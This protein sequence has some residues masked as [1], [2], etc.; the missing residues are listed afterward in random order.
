MEILKKVSQFIDANQ[1]LQENERI[2]V[3]VSGGSDSVVMLHILLK[4]GFECVVAHCNFHLRGEESMRDELFVEKLAESYKIS[5]KKIDFDTIGYAKANKISIEMAARELR[6]NWFRSQAQLNKCTSIA[7]A[8]HSDDSIETLLLN[9]IRGTGLK[10][11]TGI[12]PKNGNI[13]RPLLTCSRSEIENYAQKHK[14]EFVTDSTNKESDFSRNKIRNIIL[15]LMAEVNPSVKKSMAENIARLRGAWYIY[16]EK[17][18][19]I[20][21]EIT[22]S[23]GD[24]FY[25]N[26]EKVKSHSEPQTVLYEILQKFHFHSDVVEDVYEGLDKPAGIRFFSD[27]HRLLKDREY[28]IVDIIEPNSKLEYSIE[29]NKTSIETPVKVELRKLSWN[30]EFIFSKSADKIHIDAD[31]VK[32]PLTLR[33]WKHG[34]SFQPFGM[35]TSKKLSDFFIDEKINRNQKEE[36]WLLES[37]NK[38]VWIIGI[39]LDDRFKITKHTQNILEIALNQ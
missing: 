14:L 25:I 33:K 17:I 1:L 20:E 35:K 4:L 3:G 38:I 2:L 15:P 11:L 22:F 18:A 5:Y 34:D 7:T 6:Y 27:T 28:L 10:G 21:S 37:E 8:H 26:I 23:K 29:E 13:V 12:E 30:K 31:K 16:A 24:Q 9:L 32:F 36:L 19:E 39:R